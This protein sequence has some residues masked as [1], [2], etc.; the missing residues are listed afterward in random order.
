MSPARDCHELARRIAIG[1]RLMADLL[2]EDL[3]MN[4]ETDATEQLDE[5]PPGEAPLDP[6]AAAEPEPSGAP[7]EPVEAPA[8]QRSPRQ[9]LLK[10]SAEQFD[11]AASLS[12][13]EFKT[14]FNI[15]VRTVLDTK[16]AKAKEAVPR[17]AAELLEAAE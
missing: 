3:T 2:D 1:L 5:R 14:A 10:I 7:V 9:L 17:L 11:L 4:E 12:P 6:P 15:G 16:A 13:E 8:E